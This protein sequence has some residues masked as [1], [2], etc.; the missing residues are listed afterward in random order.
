MSLSMILNY[1]S[2]SFEADLESSK[3]KILP[4]IDQHKIKRP[5]FFINVTHPESFD[6]RIS[7]L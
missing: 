6:S 2:V 7:C 3:S 1:Y 5:I 4:I